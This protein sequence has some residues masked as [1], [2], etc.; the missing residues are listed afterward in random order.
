ML[1]ALPKGPERYNP[2][3]FPERAIQRRNTVIELM[4]DAKRHQRRRRRARRRRIRSSSR[5]ASRRARSRR[6]SSSGFASSSTRSSASSSTSRVSRST[7]RSTS[8]CSRRPSA[9]WSARFARSRPGSTARIRTSAT[10]STWRAA[11]RRAT[12]RRAELAVSAGRVHRDGSAHRRR[13]RA[14]RRPRLRRQQVRSRDAGAA[15]AGL[16]VQADRLRRRD[17]E[18]TPAVVHRSTTRRSPCRMGGRPTWTPQNFEGDFDGQDPDAPRALS[19]AQHRRR[20]SSAW[21]SARRASSTRRASSAS[22]RRFPPYPSIFIGAADVYPI[23]MV[24]AYS[25]FATLGT[26]AQPMAI[27]RVEDSEGRRPL[28]AGADDASPVMSPEEAWLMVSMM[29]DVVQR[30]TAAGSVGAQFHYPAGGKTGTTNDGTDVWFIGYTSDLVAGV[31]MGFDKPQKIKANAQ[32]GILAAPAWTAFMNEVYRRKP[33]PPDWPMPGGHRHAT[34]RRHDEHARDA[35]LPARRRSA[36]SSSFRAPI[37]SCRATCTPARCIRIRGIG[38]RSAGLTRP[39]PIRRRRRFPARRADR[40]AASA[41]T[42]RRSRDSAIFA[43]PPRDTS[44]VELTRPRRL[45]SRHVRIRARDHGRRVRFHPT[46]VAF[47]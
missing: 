31:W 20:S 30:G 46:P 22:R 1:A 2:R 5:R 41:D 11:E 39:T 27:V 10:R 6:T 4:R 16:D 9:R 47:H 3:R 34:D 45:A 12:E 21:S 18:R 38:T 17:S 43:L 7:P 28:G 24:A 25:A 23:E 19:V 32:G 40:P 36:T 14:R 35:V 13:S 44:H 29:K 37:R 42:S 8:T 33:A 26:R 15:A